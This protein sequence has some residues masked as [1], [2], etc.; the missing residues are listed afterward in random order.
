MVLGSFSIFDSLL[1]FALQFSFATVQTLF[2]SLLH[3]NFILPFILPFD[4]VSLSSRRLRFHP[5]RFFLYRTGFYW[6]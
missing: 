1:D 2:H 3:Y 5:A 4:P 6:Q